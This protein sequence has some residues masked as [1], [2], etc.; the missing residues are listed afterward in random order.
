MRLAINKITQVEAT[1]HRP[2]IVNG[3]WTNCSP[4]I[5][6]RVPSI[7]LHVPPNFTCECV[8]KRLQGIMHVSAWLLPV[9][10]LQL[11]QTP[12]SV[13]MFLS[14]RIS[15]PIHNLTVKP[16]NTLPQV[17]FVF[18]QI[19]SV[20]LSQLQACGLDMLFFGFGCYLV[21]VSFEGMRHSLS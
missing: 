20:S 17:L 6:G 5:T 7:T 11:I 18:V 9:S 19:L 1:N 4:F 21:Q 12:D 2:Y 16:P 8:V 10:C 14:P 15:L 13:C 3:L